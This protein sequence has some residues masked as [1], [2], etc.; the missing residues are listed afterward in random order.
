MLRRAFAKDTYNRTDK[1]RTLSDNTFKR[2]L[3]F[4]NLEPVT[5]ERRLKW[6]QTTLAHRSHHTSYLG[7]SNGIASQ[8]LILMVPHR[9]VLCLLALR[10]LADDFARFLLSWPGFV[11]GWV[12]LFLEPV[13]GSLKV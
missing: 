2:R 13:L 1:L 9:T 10:Q 11:L 5:R 7:H 3:N 4:P 6:Y 12:R 8:I